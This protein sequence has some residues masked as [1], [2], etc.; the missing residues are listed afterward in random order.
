MLRSKAA[1]DATRST[2]LQAPK[3]LILHCRLV[4]YRRGFLEA[5]RKCGEERHTAMLQWLLT[6]FKSHILSI[7]PQFIQ[8][9]S[10]LQACSLLQIWEVASDSSLIYR[11]CRERVLPRLVDRKAA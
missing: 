10:L 7:D 6:A 1:T 2:E 11:Q 9:R 3:A 8:I 4:G 5:I